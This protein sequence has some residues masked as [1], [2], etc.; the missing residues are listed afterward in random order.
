M[1]SKED[2]ENRVKD[3][4]KEIKLTVKALKQEEYSDIRDML[5]EEGGIFVIEKETLLWVLGVKDKL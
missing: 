4:T 3:I 1:K 5:R 2:I